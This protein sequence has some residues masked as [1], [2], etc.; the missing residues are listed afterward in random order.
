MHDS[1]AHGTVAAARKWNLLRMIKINFDNNNFLCVQ[2][3]AAFNYPCDSRMLALFNSLYSYIAI[4]FS[5]SLLYMR[6]QNVRLPFLVA[7][8]R[9]EHTD[10]NVICVSV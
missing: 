4:E 2:C 1:L 8:A 3:P 5:S 7:W 10:N 9:T 6:R